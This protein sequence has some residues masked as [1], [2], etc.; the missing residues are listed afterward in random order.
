MRTHVNVSPRARSQCLPHR[1]ARV[2]GMVNDGSRHCKGQPTACINL[3]APHR[4]DLPG[5]AVI[6]GPLWPHDVRRRRPSIES[7]RLPLGAR[8]PCTSPHHCRGPV[9]VPRGCLER[10]RAR[11]PTGMGR[12]R[13]DLAGHTQTRGD[14]DVPATRTEVAFRAPRC[15]SRGRAGNGGPLPRCRYCVVH[16]SGGGPAGHHRGSRSWVEVFLLA[17]CGH[18]RTGPERGPRPSDR[19]HCR[20]RAL[21]ARELRALGCAQGRRLREPAAVRSGHA[22][23]GTVAGAA[24]NKGGP[25]VP[26]VPGP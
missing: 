2:T 12:R 4:V 15:G 17:R 14:S 11:Y 25:Y 24:V 10:W 21:S 26:A 23:L 18:G 8:F 6:S 9:F 22:P 5:S 1:H 16:G 13:V 3:L 20:G 19:H 7:A